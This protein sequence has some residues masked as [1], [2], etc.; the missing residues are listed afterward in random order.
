MADYETDYESNLERMQN[1]IEGDISKGEGCLVGFALAPAAAEIEEIY[2][3]LE[4]ADANSSPITCDKEH[5]IVFGSDD[6][7]PI[8]EA[9]PA[10]WLAIFNEDFEVGERFECGDM[11]YLSTQKIDTGK[12]YLECETLGVEGNK[13]PDDEL[14]PIEF[15]SENFAGELTEIVQE[16]A[17][18]EDTEVYRE[19]YL[20]E[21]KTDNAMAGNRAAYKKMITSLAG[22]AAVKMVRVTEERKRIEAYILSSQYGKPTDEVISA[23][24][25]TIDPLEQQGDGAGKAPWWHVVDIC[26]VEETT[27]NIKAK[28]TLSEGETF[29][30]IL[31][32]LEA[33]VDE[34]FIDLNKTW[35][36]E[37]N[38][39]VRSLRVAEKMA[40]V[41]GVVD[42][43]EM[44][45]N[46]LDSN[47]ELGEFAI[48]VRGVI[49]NV[50]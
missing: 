46:E 37:K 8:K 5:L 21:K 36:E 31:D 4:V 9:S 14:L 35:E 25:S 30:N 7:I 20:T 12:Y 34:Y 47:L 26:P 43:Q 13:K 2:N 50:N 15:I 49:E 48:P 24:Q 29:E 38:I 32:A 22:V 19:R 27:I 1:S 40:A 16:A 42:I 45:M 44:T 17:D 33:A 3:N 18:E 10:I 39:V 11:T 6:N 23:A 41:T 28:F